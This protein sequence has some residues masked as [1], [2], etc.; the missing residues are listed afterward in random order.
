MSGWAWNTSDPLTKRQFFVLLRQGVSS[1]AAALSVGVSPNCGSLWFIDAG[2]VKFIDTPVSDLDPIV[3]GQVAAADRRIRELHAASVDEPQP[4][5]QLGDT[6]TL[7][8]AAWLLTP[9]RSNTKNWRLVSGSDLFHAQ[10]DIS[11]PFHQDSLRSLETASNP[12]AGLANP[13]SGASTLSVI[14]LIVSSGHH[15]R[16]TPRSTN[17]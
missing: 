3:L 6:P 2:S 9:C 10:R 8:A 17:A 15:E 5:Q 13:P 4:P 7:S 1:H 14:L 11:H 16:Q 12:A